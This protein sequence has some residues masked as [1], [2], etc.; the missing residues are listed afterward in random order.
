MPAN[1]LHVR[2]EYE[3]SR[4]IKTTTKSTKYV[5]YEMIVWLAGWLVGWMKL[6]C[7]PRSPVSHDSM[8]FCFCF[9]VNV[10]L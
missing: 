3:E 4:K 1:I 6:V 8:R 9:T 7:A 5:M 10:D 2:N